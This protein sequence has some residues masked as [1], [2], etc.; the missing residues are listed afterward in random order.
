MR[1]GN[2]R[3]MEK[4]VHLSRRFLSPAAWAVRLH[5]L[6]HALWCR[7]LHFLALCVSCFSRVLTCVEIHPMAEIGPGFRVV[8]GA[9]TVIGQ[10]VKFGSGC[11][12]LQGATIGARR[13]VARVDPYGDQPTI[14]DRVI[15]GPNAMVLGGITIG[16]GATVGA[17]A[18]VLHDVPAGWTAVGNP[19]RNLPPKEQRR[20]KA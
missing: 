7:N 12:V 6:A 5:R 9:G 4:E 19:A 1:V 2:G 18:V 13:Y 16:D 3:F 17:G 15:I 14:G 10:A 20:V 8:H 11:T